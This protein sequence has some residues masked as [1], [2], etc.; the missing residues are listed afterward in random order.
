MHREG[1]ATQR[2][3]ARLASAPACDGKTEAL[4]GRAWWAAARGGPTG[5]TEGCFYWR[6]APYSTRATG[7]ETRSHGRLTPGQFM[8]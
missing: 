4:S 2:V 1:V 6:V 5:R 7:E 8:S 3:H